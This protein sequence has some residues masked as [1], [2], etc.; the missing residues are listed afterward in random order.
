MRTKTKKYVV[1]V[2]EESTN[3]TVYSNRTNSL[4]SAHWSASRLR[5]IYGCDNVVIVDT[6]TGAV[7]EGL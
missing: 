2:T 1:L 6:R 3:A 7:I 4:F 5:A